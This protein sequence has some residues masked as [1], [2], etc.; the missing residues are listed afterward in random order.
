ML[1][2]KVSGWFHLVGWLGDEFDA[3]A[4][5]L[6]GSG[7]LAG[8]WLGRAVLDSFQCPPCPNI[9]LA[10]KADE[11]WHRRLVPGDEVKGMVDEVVQV[12][13][14]F[15]ADE[16][17]GEVFFS[18]A[19]GRVELDLAGRCREPSYPVPCS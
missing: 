7:T 12:D 4:E 18:G 8:D 11:G 10:R 6:F 16:G 1:R 17:D 3:D 14:R 9:L 5:E 19:G 2:S 13:G 15:P